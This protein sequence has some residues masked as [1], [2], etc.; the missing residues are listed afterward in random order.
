MTDQR[1]P[2][3]YV[4]SEDG[5][6]IAYER[7]GSGLPLIVI[8]GALCHRGLTAPTAVAFARRGYE[9]INFDRR[10]RVRAE[11]ARRT[12]SSERS[13]TCVRSPSSTTHRAPAYAHS[14]GAGLAIHAASAN[15]L[16]DP[17]VLP[18]APYNPDI[19]EMK[20]ESRPWV[21]ELGDLFDAA[22]PGDAVAA[23]MQ[24]TGMPEELIAELRETPRWQELERMAPTS[25]AWRRPSPTTRR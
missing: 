15:V 24:T 9:V 5:T 16:T 2:T 23:F 1:P 22:R 7:T 4:R 3:N 12:R 8:G 6:E 10:G 21:R 25:S 14:S 13:R 18:E 19:E 11:T 20:V 17:L